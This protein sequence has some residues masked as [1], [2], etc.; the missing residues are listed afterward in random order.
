[1]NRLEENPCKICATHLCCFCQYKEKRYES[2]RRNNQESVWNFNWWWYWKNNEQI[3]TLY[4][5]GK[6]L[7]SHDG[8]IVEETVVEEKT[9]EVKAEEVKPVV[10]QK[11][12][13]ASDDLL[14]EM[15]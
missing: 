3:E 2:I 9:D 14:D 1:M 15:K 10:E 4:N 11:L 7:E 6:M 12:V 5:T 13:D 8:T